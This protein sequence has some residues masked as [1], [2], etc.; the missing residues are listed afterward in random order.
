[1]VVRKRP[2]NGAG[3]FPAER[4]PARTGVGHWSRSTVPSREV[5]DVEVEA[6]TDRQREDP[7][8]DARR[9]I[10]R[11]LNRDP[12]DVWTRD[13]LARSVG[14]SVGLTGK[15]LVQLTGAGIVHRLE[16]PDEEYTVIGDRD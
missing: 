9:A 15:I 4:L 13:S 3:T 14:L 16:G 11:L 6:D 5:T 8:A 7:E 12:F 2:A 10:V 1:M